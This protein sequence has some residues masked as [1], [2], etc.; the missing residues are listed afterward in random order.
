MDVLTRPAPVAD[1]RI[2]Y[3]EGPCQFGDLWIPETEEGASGFPLVVFFHGG[4]WKSTYDLVYAGHLCAALKSVGVAVWS[5]EYR[6]VGETGGGLPMTFED[7]AAGLEFVA[8]LAESYSIDLKRVITMGHSAGGH[9]ALWSAGKGRIET[10]EMKLPVSRIKLV[11]AIA[12]A[13]AVDLRMT[14]ELAGEGVFA[15]DRDEIS[16]LMGG[17]PEAVPERYEVGNPG[18]L[19]PFGMPQILIQGTEDDQIPPGLPARWARAAEEAG[20]E[21]T[22][23]MIAGADHMDVVDPESKAWEVVRA[24]VSDFLLR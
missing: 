13:G 4:W 23:E 1:H 11:G 14:I 3:G 10:G 18:D 22:V 16:A 19:L 24:A 8:T 15:H 12:L 6:R 5:V 17:L 21:V 9:L 20:D 2:F 7:A